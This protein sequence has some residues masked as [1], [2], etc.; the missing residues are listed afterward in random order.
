MALQLILPSKYR[1]VKS[2]CLICTAKFYEGEEARA[3]AHAKKC[4]ADHIDELRAEFKR[5]R[6]A[7][8]FSD[9][10]PEYG[11]WVREHGRVG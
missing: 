6:P 11:A 4:A 2:R 10:D 1:T 3:V 8:L 5:Q 9:L 7:G